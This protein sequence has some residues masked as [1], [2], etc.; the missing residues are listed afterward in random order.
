MSAAAAF[1]LVAAL[2]TAP[3]RAEEAA[4]PVDKMALYKADAAKEEA[5]RAAAPSVQERVAKDLAKLKQEAALDAEFAAKTAETPKASGGKKASKKPSIIKKEKIISPADE[6]DEDE[7][8]LARSNPV[9]L[10]LLAT[11]IPG[12]YLVFY[13]LGS[14]DV[15]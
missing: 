2:A 4:A 14:L 8:S 1:G 9:A 6:L 15:I 13:V 12:I 3:V 5:A 7:K 11:V 10:F